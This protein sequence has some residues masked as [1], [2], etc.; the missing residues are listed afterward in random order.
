MRLGATSPTA[1]DVAG[2]GNDRDGEMRRLREENVFLKKLLAESRIEVQ[3][4]LEALDL[5]LNPAAPFPPGSF[6]EYSMC[7]A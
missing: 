5:T 6:G 2:P 3:G 1:K 4:L 7:G